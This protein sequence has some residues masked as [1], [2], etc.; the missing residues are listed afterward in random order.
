MK[1]IGLV[2]LVVRGAAT[3]TF[4]RNGTATPA[5]DPDNGGI[6]LPSGFSVVFAADGVGVV[7]RPSGLEED[8]NTIRTMLSV[9]LNWSVAN[10]C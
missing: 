10:A 5:R 2:L 7:A 9:R 1:R 3:G 4:S 8:Q 6:Q